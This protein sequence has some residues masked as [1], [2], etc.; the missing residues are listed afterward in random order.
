M[1]AVGEGAARNLDRRANVDRSPAGSAGT[2]GVEV[3]RPDSRHALHDSGC[4]GC[5]LPAMDDRRAAARITAGLFAAQSV[6]SAGIIAS[7]TVAAI[8]G[9]ELSGRAYLSGVPAAVF[10]LGGAFTALLVGVWNERFGRRGGLTLG[11]ALGAAGMALAVVSS[12][13]GAFLPLLVGLMLAGTASAAVKLGRFT[14]A[15][16]NP[17]QRRGRAVSVVVLGGTVGSV[18]GPALVGPAGALTRAWG[19]GELAGPYLATLLLFTLAAV[20]F[21][22]FLRPEPRELGARIVAAHPEVD[23]SHGHARPFRVLLRDPGVVTAIGVMVLAQ[24][25]MVMLM[26]ITPLHMRDHA[27]A[28]TSISGV[29]AGHTLGMF[30]FSLVSG[31][32]TDRWG[33]GPVLLAGGL[34]L[35]AS[36]ALAPLSTGFLALFAALFLLGFGWNLCFVAGSALL[37][38]RLSTAEKSR[39][40]GTNDLL[41]GLV[42]AG[43]SL[44][45]GVAYAAAGFGAMS[46]A[47]GV[48]SVAILLLLGRHRVRAVAGLRAG[49]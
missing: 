19:W 28:L 15:E 16:V 3:G 38:D 17:P 34:V 1:Q 20:A 40:Q 32:L 31:W 10:Q 36:C 25:A 2:G 30:A 23:P 49:W 26:A 41:M 13:W 35:T 33:R 7:A 18:L 24:G 6:G 9:A 47:A 8:V 46:W 22:V 48:V 11:A 29:F 27:H 43:S 44:G 45:G 21:A 12:V 5:T 42:S 4:V 39:T 37:T 14:A